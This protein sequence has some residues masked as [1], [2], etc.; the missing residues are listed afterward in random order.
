MSN[1]ADNDRFQV[2]H[3]WVPGDSATIT[4]TFDV[5]LNGGVPEALEPG[6]L[7]M[8]DGSGDAIPAAT[9]ATAK[10]IYLVVEGNV[11]DTSTQSFADLVH[12]V[13]CVRGSVTI[14]TPRFDTGAAIVAG[15]PLSYANGLLTLQLAGTDQL[16]GYAESVDTTVGS[17]KLVAELTL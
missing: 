3:G 9:P 14:T 5:A 17:E 6:M 7:V 13:A 4:R 15:S 8:L 16:V 11:V 12:K 2:L 10:S 1:L